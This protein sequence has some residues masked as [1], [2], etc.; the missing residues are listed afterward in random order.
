MLF[1]LLDRLVFS[2]P[3]HMKPKCCVSQFLFKKNWMPKKN[4]NFTYTYSVSSLYETQNEYCRVYEQQL[5]Y[6]KLIMHKN[7]D[8][9]K[10]DMDYS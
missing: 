3:P 6:E 5:L 4:D 10:I 9:I 7:A 8:H 1:L 2:P